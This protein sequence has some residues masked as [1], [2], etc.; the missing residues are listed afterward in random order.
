MNRS[1]PERPRIS[2]V[3]LH[4]N[5]P[6]F[7]ARCFASLAAGTRAPYEAIVVDNGSRELPEAVCAAHGARLLSE[8][9]PGP[10]SA[11]NCGV[12]ASSG[13]LLAFIDADCVAY[14][15]WSSLKPLWPTLQPPYLSQSLRAPIFPVII[16]RHIA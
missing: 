11:R 15:G 12:A 6:E 2:V 16:A 10:G 4:L 5:P 7:L 13:E 9:E 3:I 1:G 8:A 14:P